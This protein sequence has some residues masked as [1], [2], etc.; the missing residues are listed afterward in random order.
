MK[1][2]KKKYETPARP[3]D[4]ERIEKE[5]LVVSRFGLS[6]KKEIFK[7]QAIVR[8]FR[9]MAR[10][11]AATHDKEKESVLINKMVRL[12]LLAEGATLDDVLG[13][14]FENILERRLQTIVKKRGLAN[15]IRQARQIIT[16]GHVM[17]ND[18]KITHPSYIVPKN[19]EGIITTDISLGKKEPSLMMTTVKPEEAKKGDSTNG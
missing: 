10:E 14:T 15:T 18:R 7:S 4:K 11:I 3:W 16:H 19:E 17:I 13:L 9:R 12:G 6:R 8:K 5:R 1:R 2:Q